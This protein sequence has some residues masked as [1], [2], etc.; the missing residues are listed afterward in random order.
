MFYDDVINWKYFPRYW[1]FVR[2]I[3]RFP[4]NSPHK[5]QWRGA[6]TFLWYAPWINAW[7]NNREAGDLRRH[8]AHYDVIV[9]LTRLLI[10]SPLR[11]ET[12]KNYVSRFL[13]SHMEVCPWRFLYTES[14]KWASFAKKIRWTN[15]EFRLWKSN[16]TPQKPWAKLYIHVQDSLLVKSMEIPYCPGRPVQNFT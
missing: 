9:M 4:V 1:S 11:C 16:C 5:G 3:H 15:N 13:L 8:R 2:G 6:L 14:R 10:V 12:F 7:V